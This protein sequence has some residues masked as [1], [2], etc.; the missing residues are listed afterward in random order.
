MRASTA[1]LLRGLEVPRGR[2]VGTGA[3]FCAGP[4]GSWLGASEEPPSLFHFEAEAPHVP[5]SSPLLG[6]GLRDSPVICRL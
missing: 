2:R 3:R 6:K 1:F 5:L 4:A